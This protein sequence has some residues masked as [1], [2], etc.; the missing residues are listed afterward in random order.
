MKSH[1]ELCAMTDTEKLEYLHDEVEKIIASA[2]PNLVL[3]LRALQ[4]RLDGVRKRVHNPIVSLNI[5][6][7]E[8]LESLITLN[9]TLKPL[10]N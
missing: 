7:E 6:Y 4:A 5:I 8:M 3:K 10:E 9:E 1:D 2:P